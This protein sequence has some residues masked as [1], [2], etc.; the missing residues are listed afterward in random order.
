MMHPH[1]MLSASDK[2]DSIGIIATE[3]IPKGTVTWA[4]D[5]L[6]KMFTAQEVH[7][8]KPFFRNFIDRYAYRNRNGSYILC[9]DHARFIG[10]SYHANCITTAY[11]FDLA[12]RDIFPGEA[13]TNDYGFLNLPE[14]YHAP[15]EAECNRTAVFPDDLLQY[16]HIWDARL[17]SAFKRF[18]LVPQYLSELIESR[19]QQQVRLV[20]GGQEEMDSILNCYFDP[21]NKLAA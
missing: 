15:A 10:H 11:N 7:D 5:T 2:K 19:F 16:C 21:E 9:W 8:M 3:F 4:L 12:V 17:K 1:T 20:A 6:D 18:N 14:V 13:L